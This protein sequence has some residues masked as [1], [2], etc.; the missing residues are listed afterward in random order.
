M[1]VPNGLC[2]YTRVLDVIML[3]KV[4]ELMTVHE[5]CREFGTL[6]MSTAH[7]G[8]KGMTHGS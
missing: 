3:Y 7:I 1:L 4:Y 6:K 2:I 5:K 8:E